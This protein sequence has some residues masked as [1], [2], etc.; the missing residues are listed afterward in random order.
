MHID[1]DA[2]FASVEQ[3]FNPV[4]RN[5]PVIVGGLADQRG[6][7][8]TA[9]YD[10]RARGVHTGMALVRAHTLCPDAV[11]FKGDQ[12]HYRA[13]SD[14]LR[15]IYEG[16]TPQVE[17]T[18]LDDAYL[19][20]SGTQGLHGSPV[21]TARSIRD[22]VARALG[23]SVSVGIGRTK[24]IARIA[25]GLQKPAGIVHIAPEHE[26]A[27]I[28]NLSVD[29]LP[30]IGR[31]TRQKLSELGIFKVSQLA[32]LPRFPV[33]QL[34]GKN[35]TDFWEMAHGRDRRTIHTTDMPRQIS[36]E[37]SLEKDTAD[38]AL[39]RG[40]L[41]YLCER[42]ARK[43]QQGGW[44]C[45][46]V[47]LKIGY[48]DFT[49][50]T[51]SR[52]CSVQNAADLFSVVER[53][54][55]Q[56]SRRRVRIRHLGICA[57]HLR[58]RDDQHALFYEVSRQEELNAAIETLRNRFGFM[59]VMPADTLKLKSAYRNDVHGYILHNPALTR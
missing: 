16:Y 56:M 9:S 57:M 23:I 29:Q 13:A 41:H 12:A 52:A 15:R 25:S 37:T 48:A 43:L 28:N 45:G 30:G 31:V 51:Q 11:F 26:Q 17:F 24:M 8:H 33:E 49:R 40:M 22:E 55:K 46:S 21:Y 3:G 38:S 53:L 14:T 47:A 58:K 27:F 50:H 5:R 35:G 20:L 6:V 18:S 10:A 32:R 54:Y 59:A 44:T 39:I 19:D 42:I 4:L 36:R 34:F 2:F 1:A 7:V